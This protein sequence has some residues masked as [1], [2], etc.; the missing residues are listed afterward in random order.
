MGALLF[1]FENRDVARSLGS[2]PSYIFSKLPIY[3]AFVRRREKN[4]VRTWRD[5]VPP[6]E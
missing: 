2:A 3:A 1:R 5:P 4:W 6:P